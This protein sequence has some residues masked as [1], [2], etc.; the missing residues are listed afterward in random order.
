MVPTSPRRLVSLIYPGVVRVSR[1]PAD[2]AAPLPPP[3]RAEA[4]RTIPEAGLHYFPGAYLFSDQGAVLTRDNRLCDE[5]VHHFDT[6]PL[7]KGPYFRPFATFASDVE[8]LAGWVA[9]LAAPEG[10]QLL[11]LAV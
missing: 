5:F 1:P 3:F 6:V 8:R 7:A 9:L 11:S 2:S 10:A 4:V